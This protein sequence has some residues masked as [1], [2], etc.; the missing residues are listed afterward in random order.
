MNFMVDYTPTSIEVESPQTIKLDNSDFTEVLN[1]LS[2]II[3][4]GQNEIRQL[5]A[6]IHH[7]HEKHNI[8]PE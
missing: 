2:Q 7:I 1:T 8:K 3:L 5:R 6:Y 4:R